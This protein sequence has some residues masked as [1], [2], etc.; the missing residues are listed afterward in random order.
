MQGGV[1]KQELLLGI[2]LYL[3]QYR[4]DFLGDHIGP[5]CN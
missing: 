4:V 3:D 1:T 5:R 2:G